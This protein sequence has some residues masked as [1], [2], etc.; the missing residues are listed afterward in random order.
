MTSIADYI[1]TIARR[2]EKINE[3]KIWKQKQNKE[4]NLTAWEKP[5]RCVVTKKSPT[6]KECGTSADAKSQ[7]RERY[8]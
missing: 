1:F 4:R 7:I 6:V 2:S 5:A 8:R 3:V